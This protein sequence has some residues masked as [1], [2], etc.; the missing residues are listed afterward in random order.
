[1][2]VIDVLVRLNTCEY[3]QI[4]ARLEADWNEENPYTLVPAKVKDLGWLFVQSVSG[5][6]VVEIASGTVEKDGIKD[7]CV[8]LVYR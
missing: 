5:R 1:M 4:H 8:V 7:T 6:E 3:V 2:K